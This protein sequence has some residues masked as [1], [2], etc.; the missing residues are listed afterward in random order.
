MY[1]D[2]D[3]GKRIV[4]ETETK[5]RPSDY[6]GLEDEAADSY[7]GR[8]MRGKRTNLQIPTVDPIVMDRALKMLE[9]EIPAL[10]AALKHIPDRRLK[11]S[12][13]VSAMN[14]WNGIMARW[15]GIKYR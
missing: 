4:A 12:A 6:D 1:S 11:R 2:P 14:R 5:K 7:E 9:E 10:R 15:A 8:M 3:A 13:A